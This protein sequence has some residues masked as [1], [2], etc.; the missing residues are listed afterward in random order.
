MAKRRVKRTVARGVLAAAREARVRRTAGK[1]RAGKVQ[2]EDVAADIKEEV[3]S[4][5]VRRR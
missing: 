3:V 4:R 1:V 5:G 2:V